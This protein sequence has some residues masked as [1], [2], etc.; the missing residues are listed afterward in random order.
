MTA[1]VLKARMTESD[2]TFGLSLYGM[3]CQVVTL[4]VRHNV[5]L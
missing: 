3:H 4:E 5:S 1:T 2:E